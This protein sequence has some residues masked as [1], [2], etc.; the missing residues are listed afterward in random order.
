MNTNEQIKGDD[1]KVTPM[2][3][4]NQ[5]D[6]EKPERDV[7]DFDNSKDVLERKEFRK[8][9]YL[10]SVFIFA[11]FVVL[12]ASIKNPD[13]YKI[14]PETGVIINQ[15]FNA[16]IL[17]MVPLILGAVGAVARILISGLSLPQNATLVVSSGLFAM[18]SWVGI[19][20]GVLLAI[21]APHLEPRG[22]S[23]AQI[24]QAPSEFYTMALVAIFVGMFSTNVYL[25]VNN[26]LEKITKED[27]EKP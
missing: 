2:D 22:I 3:K 23:S 26:K 4:S 11:L 8:N 25:F 13:I 15:A 14:E 24:S 17:L 1:S 16:V 27:G 12:M 7:F 19:K 21:V 5:S 9:L 18:F 6:T 20:S 10:G